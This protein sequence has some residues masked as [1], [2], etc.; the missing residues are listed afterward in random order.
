MRQTRLIAITLLAAAMPS[1]AHARSSRS[2]ER[3]TA[4]SAP[5]TLRLR[6]G[7]VP[8]ATTQKGPPAHDIPAAPLAVHLPLIAGATA[9]ELP[10][11]ATPG[12]VILPPAYRK[13]ATAEFRVPI[14]LRD[15][16]NWYRQSLRS[17]GFAVYGTTVFVPGHPIA[18]P[19]LEAQSHNGLIWPTVQFHALDPRVTLIRYIVQAFDLPPRPAGS[20]L[21]GPFVR[22]SVLYDLHTVDPGGNRTDRFQITWPA[23]IA[24]LEQRVNSLRQISTAFS[25]G[26][27]AQVSS[28]R[29]RIGFQRRD[30]GTRYVTIAPTGDVAVG[31]TRWLADTNDVVMKLVS[32]L[33]QRRCH[34]MTCG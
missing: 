4:C 20:Y 12:A 7:H 21:R 5:L 13:I 18:F 16:Y 31:K 24:R 2:V 32:R 17:C 19:L 3:S 23:T 10:F 27:G 30:G 28:I 11:V 8:G 34:G 29:V 1:V 15:A 25:L 22:A 33:V 14:S 26:G 9:S 6:P